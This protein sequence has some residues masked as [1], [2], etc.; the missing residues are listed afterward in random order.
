MNSL[1]TWSLSSA[2][3]KTEWF[4]ACNICLTLKLCS[5]YILLHLKYKWINLHSVYLLKWYHAPIVLSSF[6]YINI[7][8]FISNKKKTVNLLLPLQPPLH[9][10]SNYSATIAYQW[11]LITVFKIAYNDIFIVVTFIF[12]WGLLIYL[13]NG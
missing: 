1:E 13:M 5:H 7:Y 2:E 12:F 8:I 3:Y 9:T 4:Q 6:G 10:Q 11:A